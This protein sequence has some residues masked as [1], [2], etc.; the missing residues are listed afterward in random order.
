[1]A[2]VTTVLLPLPKQRK[3]NMATISVQNL[4]V[5]PDKNISQKVA[6]TKW[7]GYGGTSTKTQ[8]TSTGWSTSRRE[9]PFLHSNSLNLDLNP[10]RKENVKAIV[11]YISRW[12]HFGA[13]VNEEKKAQAT[14]FVM[15]ALKIA[16]ESISGRVYMVSKINNL[17]KDAILRNEEFK[18]G[19]FA[20]KL[21]MA[22]FVSRER[23]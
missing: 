15:K 13:D 2:V 7:A 18:T 4:T 22:L 14:E 17:R 16:E 11:A 6:K 8:Y 12:S 9:K 1:M 5:S 23:L 21:W 19:K 10:N 3:N 20:N